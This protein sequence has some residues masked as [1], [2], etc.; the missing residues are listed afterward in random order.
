V[1]KHFQLAEGLN[2]ANLRRLNKKSISWAK[3]IDKPMN[4][5]S[6]GHMT[7]ELGTALTLAYGYDVESF[8]NSIK[9]GHSILLGK[10]RNLFLTLVREMKKE[11]NYL[12][13]AHK[14]G[15]GWFWIKTHIKKHDSEVDALQRK[16]QD[17][18]FHDNYALHHIGMSK[19]D[20]KHYLKLGKGL[21]K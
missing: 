17:K 14:S 6:D 20:Y 1:Q 8:L 16:L 12:K 9:K 18:T 19:E 3:F 11:K 7:K 21:F 15:K 10:E 4:A 5:G 13:R 2:G